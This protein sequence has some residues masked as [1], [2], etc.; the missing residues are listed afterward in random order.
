MLLA[1]LA[2]VAIVPLAVS[3]YFL[4][5]INRESLETLEKKYLTRAAVSI[6][7]DI[8]TLIAGNTQ[9]L[10][11][12]GGSV[13]VMRR[14]LPP[15]TDPFGYIARRPSPPT[16]ICWRCAFSMRPAKERRRS[17]RAWTR[18]FCRRWISRVRPR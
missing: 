15:D 11:T 9:E 13:L 18:R 3:H 5:G 14:A 10:N 17:P 16:A 1:A 7:T 6:A 8:Q 4:I 2:L 12:I